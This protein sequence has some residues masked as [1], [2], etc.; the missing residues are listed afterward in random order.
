MRILLLSGGVDS[1]VCLYRG[2]FDA[3]LFVDY[4]QPA[5]LV[6]RRRSLAFASGRGLPWKVATVSSSARTGILG[7][8]DASAVSA[9][10]PGRNSLFVGLAAMLGA[11]RVTLG[12]NADDIDAFADCRPDVLGPVAAACGVHLDLPL[13]GLTKRQVVALAHEIGAPFSAATSCYRGTACGQC[14]ACILLASALNPVDN[15]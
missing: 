7:T 8:F 12:C 10:V 15:P 3:A 2:G 9:V 1:M 5:A 4:G 6:E 14:A 13:G 11:S